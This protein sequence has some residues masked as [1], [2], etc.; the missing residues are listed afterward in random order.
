MLLSVIFEP[1]FSLLLISFPLFTFPSASCWIFLCNFTGFLAN[2]K[3][4]ISTH[5]LNLRILFFINFFFQHFLFFGYSSY[6]IYVYIIYSSDFSYI[7]F[8]NFSCFHSFIFDFFQNIR[9]QFFSLSFLDVNFA[10]ANTQCIT[11]MLPLFRPLQGNNSAKVG[12]EPV[13]PAPA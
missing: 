3:V 5:V 12:T 2:F 9:P 10:D 6:H 13:G 7:F 1:F 8:S 4:M 11:N